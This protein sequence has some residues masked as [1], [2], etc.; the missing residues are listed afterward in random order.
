MKKVLGALVVAVAAIAV[1]AEAAL[2][3]HYEFNGNL[4]DSVGAAHGTGFNG[5]TVVG[6]ELVLVDS[7]AQYVEFG[8]LLVPT[9]GSFTVA[10]FAR[11]TSPDGAFMELISQGG[12][13]GF[14]LG[15]NPGLGG[16]I[17]AGDTWISTGVG[18][19]TDGLTHHFALVRDQGANQ[20]S[21]FIDGLLVSQLGAAMGMSG[22]GTNTRLGRQYG[23]HAEFLGGTMDDVRIYNEALSAQDVFALA[24]PQTEPAPVPEPSS[25]LLMLTGAAG[26]ALARRRGK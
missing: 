5:A 9:T 10:M 24:N 23:P 1:P 26:I 22:G 18:Y 21:L 16:T 15:R 25:L 3:H 12:G 20:T 8:S 2:I 6:N 17:R 7:S 19:P 14:Y 4:N 11:E 13:P